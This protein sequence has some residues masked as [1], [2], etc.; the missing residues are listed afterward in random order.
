MRIYLMFVEKTL[1]TQIIPSVAT[2]LPHLPSSSSHP[3]G[4]KSLKSS[5]PTLWPEED[6]TFT[7]LTFLIF[8]IVQ[9]HNLWFPCFYAYSSTTFDDWPGALGSSSGSRTVAAVPSWSPQHYSALPLGVRPP[10]E[11]SSSPAPA[12]EPYVFAPPALHTQSQRSTEGKHVGNTLSPLIRV[13]WQ[14][15]LQC[16]K[17]PTLL[18]FFRLLFNLLQF[19]HQ[20]FLF[21]FN[22][23]LFL[24]CK[25][26][27][28]LFILQQSSCE[29][30]I[31]RYHIL[32]VK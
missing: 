11:P 5:Q 27:F 26:S 20:F 21:L 8:W 29:N 23:F 32:A 2:A 7:S 24:F 6:S 19:L 9:T 17:S 16:C 1:T 14:T 25:F 10:P 15:F 18:G 3:P 4:V 28:P 12:P 30:K 31:P 13:Q 22:L